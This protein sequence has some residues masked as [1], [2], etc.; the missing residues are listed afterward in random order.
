[1]GK[2]P[3][4]KIHL[5]L[6]EGAEPVHQKAYPVAHAHQAAFQKELLHLVEIGVLERCGATEW[7][8]PTFIIPKKDG[9]IRWVSDFRQLN[10]VIKRKQYPLPVIHDV[11][12][13]RSGYKFLTKIDLTMCYYTYE[14]D[15]ESADMCVIVTPYGKFK[16]KRLPMGVKQ[17]PDFAQE[18]IEEVLRGLD[19]ET[20]IDDIAAFDND[21]DS[22]MRS[23]DEI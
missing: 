4:K 20:Y 7:G 22:H 2:Y 18:I 9:R 10:A 6:L 17:S 13:R 3:H 23:L 11:L 12:R 1:L 14:L 15:D 21:W 19:V 16:Y 5:E 8:S